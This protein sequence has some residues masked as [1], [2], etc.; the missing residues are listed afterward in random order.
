MH[1]FRPRPVRKNEERIAEAQ[2]LENYCECQPAVRWVVGEENLE[3]A[4]LCRQ[5]INY[6]FRGGLLLWFGSFCSFSFSSSQFSVSH[7]FTRAISVFRSPSVISFDMR[8]EMRGELVNLIKVLKFVCFKPTMNQ[9]FEAV[10]DSP[11]RSVI[12]G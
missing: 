4:Y 7:C 1:Q 5:L 2:R 10:S 11:Q 6:G 8:R 9:M 12:Y 3:A